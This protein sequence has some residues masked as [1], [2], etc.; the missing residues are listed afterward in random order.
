M[1]SRTPEEVYDQRWAESVLERV[2]KRL[3]ESYNTNGK[4]DLFEEL[5]PFLTEKSPVSHA[6]L[7]LRHGISISAV[8]S[9]VCRLRQR[10]GEA[11]REEV[12][13]TVEDPAQVEDELRYLASVLGHSGRL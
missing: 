8:G 2:M 1:D 6:E 9:A 13:Q 5:K 3:R 11:L 4:R 12:A 7:A 10:F